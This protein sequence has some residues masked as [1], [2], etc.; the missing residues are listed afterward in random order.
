MRVAVLFSGQG[1]QQPE[2]LEQLRRTAD[3]ALW[4]ALQQAFDEAAQRSGTSGDDLNANV[5]AQPLIFALQMQRWAQIQAVVPSP[6]AMAGYSLGE[7][8]AVCAAGAFGTVAAGDAFVIVGA[9]DASAV[10]DGIGL[11][12]QRAA[13][14]DACV[15]GD[16]GLLAVRGLSAAEVTDIAQRTATSVAITNPDRHVIVGGPRAALC[17]A[18]TLAK[19]RGAART[20]MLPVHT[21]SHTPLLTEAA[22]RFRQAL[23]PWATTRPL[24]CRVLSAIDGRA[25]T[26]ADR[27]L[28]ALADQICTPLDWAR[29]LETLVELQPDAIVEI[30][31]GDALTKM[32]LEIDPH[33]AVRSLDAF[34]DLPGGLAAWLARLRDRR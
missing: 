26:T 2:H 33:I 18:E 19:E 24:S 30:G 29:C 8:A 6:V 17:S 13:A 15:D 1:A 23:A 21:P 20:V 22:Q 16:A 10:A 12:A 25:A 4:R 32:C 28:D 34:H 3:R 31:P 14:M 5:V 27:A 11:A 7:L 9:G